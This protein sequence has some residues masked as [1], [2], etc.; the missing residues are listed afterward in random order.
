MVRKSQSTSDNSVTYE[1]ETKVKETKVEYPKNYADGP[2]KFQRNTFGL[3]G[4]VNYEFA[5]D[6]SVNWRSMIKDEHLFP[7]CTF[8]IY[9]NQNQDHHQH[10]H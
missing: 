7:I 5:E 1:A 3:L 6:G 9:L 8:H 10:Q 4:D 2:G